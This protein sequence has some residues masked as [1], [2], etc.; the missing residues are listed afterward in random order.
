[1]SLNVGTCRAKSKAQ[2]IAIQVPDTLESPFPVSP[3]HFP[4]PFPRKATIALTHS[5][6]SCY[7]PASK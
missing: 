4:S 5:G 7:N 3:A 1:M 6:Y 2:V